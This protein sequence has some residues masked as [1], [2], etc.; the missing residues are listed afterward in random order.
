MLHPITSFD[1]IDGRKL[2]DLYREGNIENTAYFY[3]EI[4]DQAV[5]LQNVERDFL[6]YIKTDFLANEGNTYWVLE[7]ENTWVSALRLYPITKGL[8]YIEALETHP[9]FR[10]KGYAVRL[11][12]GVIEAL[13][14]RGPFRLCDCVGKRNPASIR[15]HQKCGFKIVSEAGFDYL[16]NEANDKDYGM[17]YSMNDTSPHSPALLPN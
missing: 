16:C 3:P 8:Y 6:S 17:E 5:A 11:L 1:D 13:R 12:K 10:R 7:E 9:S 14:E 15:T 2:M 4:T